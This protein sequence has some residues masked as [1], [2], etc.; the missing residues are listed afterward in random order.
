MASER[1]RKE[2][3]VISAAGEPEFHGSPK[4]CAG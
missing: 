2:P 3:R 1:L 4:A